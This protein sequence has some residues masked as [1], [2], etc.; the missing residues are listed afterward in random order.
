MN[1]RTRIQNY[2]REDERPSRDDDSP[3]ARGF[4]AGYHDYTFD[5]ND[6]DTA[7]RL[8]TEDAS[9]YPPKWERKDDWKRGYRDGQNEAGY[10]D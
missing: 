2:L 7:F 9:P 10:D 8:D 4:R 1:I 3:Y 5:K 6:A